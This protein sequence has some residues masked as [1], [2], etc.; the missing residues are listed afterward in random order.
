MIAAV[1]A[2]LLQVKEVPG[3]LLEALSDALVLRQ[4]SRSEAAMLTTGSGLTV[5]VTEAEAVQP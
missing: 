4:I 5:I 2:P 3:M 1:L